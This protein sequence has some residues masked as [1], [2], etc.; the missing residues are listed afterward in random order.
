[1][2][3]EQG[4][5]V[6]LLTEFV[7]LFLFFPLLL[8]FEGDLMHPSSILFPLVVF[9]F[10]ILRFQTDFKWKELWHFPV[11]RPSLLSHLGI[12]FVV[13]LLL[14]GWVYYF[15]RDNLFNL[16]AGNWKLWLLMTIFYP[17]FSV[18][19]QEIIF[20]T[21]IF[22]RYERLFGNGMTII[23]ISALVFSFAHIFYF[24][25]VSLVLTFIL[26]LYLGLIYQKTRSVLFASFM[27]GL[28]GNMVF[29]IGLGQYFWIDMLK[30]I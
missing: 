24:H 4:K 25:P 27:H 13:S 21:Y 29:T 10:I 18:F 11:T 26:G 8:L 2:E 30:W 15:D 7:L 28:Y 16:P 9:I 22:R 3:K 12:A 23:L 20:R 17:L 14:L 19:T 1:M 6:Y 5:R